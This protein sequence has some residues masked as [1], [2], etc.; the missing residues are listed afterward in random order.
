MIAFIQRVL[1]PE[2]MF[3]KAQRQEKVMQLTAQLVLQSFQPN[4]M[5]IYS[6]TNMAP[7]HQYKWIL[8]EILEAV[9]FLV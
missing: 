6:G 5:C 7:V 3:L 4:V 9:Y 2:I 8:M 1:R